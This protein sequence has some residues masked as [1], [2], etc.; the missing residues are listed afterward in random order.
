MAF[1][2]Y[3]LSDK[4]FK[5]F[6]DGDSKKEPDLSVFFDRLLA[7][8]G[9]NSSQ[10]VIIVKFKRPGRDDYDGN[11]SFV[12]QVLDYVDIF[13]SGKAVRDKS[14]TIIRKISN[15]TR[16]I[17][18]IIADLTNSLKRVVRY[19]SAANEM[20]DG[21]GYFGFSAAHNA[22]IEVIPYQKVVHDAKLRHEAFFKELGI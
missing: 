2:T 22:W 18:Y 10:P 1:Y 8:R 21:D 12:S 14:G 13:R 4:P 11:S 9:K 3:F 17:C 6:T 20:P 5:V 7:F 15:E 19:S 16:F